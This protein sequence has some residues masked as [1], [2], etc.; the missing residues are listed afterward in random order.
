MPLANTFAGV[1]EV[2]SVVVFILW[3]N[4]IKFSFDLNKFVN[5]DILVSLYLV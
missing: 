4:L 1:V 5:N 3:E 2:V